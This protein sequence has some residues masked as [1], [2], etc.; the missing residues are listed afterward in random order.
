MPRALTDDERTLVRA[1]LLDA[2]RARFARQGIR[3]TRID[4][5]A[6]DAGI[7]KGTFYQFY[8]S[9]EALFLDLHQA[10][11]GA[12]QQALT[13]ELDALA[14]Q[15]AARVRRFLTFQLEILRDHPLLHWLVDPGEVTALLVRLGPEA[16]VAEQAKDE[17]FFQALVQRMIAEG[18]V[19]DDVD[20]PA[21][22]ALGRALFAL[23]HDRAILGDAIFD[24]IVG[25][26][27]DALVA[28]LATE[29]P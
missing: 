2:A 13:A 15:P 1:R 25:T 14:G 5:L 16:L 27:I 24:R 4:E 12:S 10:D 6:S 7:G 9:K 11:E 20:V 8:D 19:R 17:V 21:V 23:L 22:A 18:D 3:K 28:H 26:L 29:A